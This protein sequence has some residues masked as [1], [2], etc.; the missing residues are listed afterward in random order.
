MSKFY[1]QLGLINSSLE[2]YL[3]LQMWTEVINCYQVLDKRG[4]VNN[5]PT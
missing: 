1:M 4:Q 5:N 3:S 2:I